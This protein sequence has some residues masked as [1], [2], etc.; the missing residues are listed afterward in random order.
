VIFIFET[1]AWARGTLIDAAADA[2]ARE[3]KNA[4]RFMLE[5]LSP[6]TQGRL[7]MGR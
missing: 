1:A 6:L 7:S 3:L 5:M 2:P 4:L